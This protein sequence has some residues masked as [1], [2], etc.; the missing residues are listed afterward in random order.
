MKMGDGGFRPAYNGQ[1][2]TE[3]GSGIVVGVAVTNQGSDRFE[4]EPFVERLTSRY[5]RAPAEVLV[6]GGYPTNEEISALA[7]CGT[8]VYAPPLPPRNRERDP[9]RT[10][11]SDP[12]AV[13]EWRTRMATPEAKFID[14]QRASH[15]E[16][17]NALARNRGLQHLPVRGLARVRAIFLWFALA[18]NVAQG[19]LLAERAGS[20]T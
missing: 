10:R 3:V 19:L 18:H 6:D 7:A 16:W 1:L 9:A 8:R 2:T 4:L 17:T 11:P 12:P 14:R 5:G 15:A 13:A 20:A